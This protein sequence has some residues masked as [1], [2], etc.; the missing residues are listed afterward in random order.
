MTKQTAGSHTLW[1]RLAVFVGGA[2]RDAT[3]AIC[4]SEGLPRDA[5]QPLLHHL[6]AESEVLAE[7]EGSD[8]RFRLPQARVA[9]AAYLLEECGED[10]ELQQR[11]AAYYL[12]LGTDLGRAVVTSPQRATL[13]AQLEHEHANLQKALGWLTTHGDGVAALE[14]AGA[15]R[16]FW[17]EGD[18]VQE[19]RDWL[20][21]LLAVPQLAEATEP[22][23]G[24]P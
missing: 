13:L 8:E 21:R 12:A 17:V 16:Y 5:V 23:G 19:G 1:R 4:T 2:T 3:E 9:H 22:A 14:L 6:V 24:G 11:H 10:A 7:R 20:M 18:H 15:L